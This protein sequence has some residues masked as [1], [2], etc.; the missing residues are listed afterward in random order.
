[1]ESIVTQDSELVLSNILMIL[2][3]NHDNQ[4]VCLAA[5]IYSMDQHRILVKNH[6]KL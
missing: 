3:K 1:M 5:G 2:V 6:G 4:R